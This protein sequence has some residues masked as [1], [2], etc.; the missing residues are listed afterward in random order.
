MQTVEKLKT[1]AGVFAHTALA[2]VS[3]LCVGSAL[4]FFSPIV[5]PITYTRFVRSAT[6]DISLTVTVVAIVAATGAFYFRL[7]RDRRALFAWTIPA[8]FSLFY[9]LAPLPIYG[10]V[11]KTD[12]SLLVLGVTLAY[13]MGA[14]VA[15]LLSPRRDSKDGP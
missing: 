12:L 10:R 1:T 4:R 3:V 14:G 5:G 11:L 6:A 13:S 7:W 9:G 15:A 8:A 2:I